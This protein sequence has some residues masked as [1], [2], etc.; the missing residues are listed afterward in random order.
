M[1]GREWQ[2]VI[3]A[4]RTNL[5]PGI[6]A[7]LIQLAGSHDKETCFVLT[8]GGVFR[9]RANPADPRTF[10]LCSGAAPTRTGT[11][12]TP[13]WDH[14]ARVLWAGG[15]IAKRYRRP[16]PNQ[17]AILTAF[18]E[19][20][21]PCRIDDPLPPKGEVCPKAR[22]H[23]TIKWLNRGQ[24]RFLLRFLGDGTGEGVCWEPVTISAL[25]SR[26]DAAKRMRL[27]A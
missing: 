7:A 11:L 10:R 3:E 4:G 8:C 9:A 2:Q 21:W 18:E 22:L 5:A 1:A 16:S 13:R 26:G 15:Q 14:E 27:A 24:K 23:D 6:R 20:G 17:E 25:L 19:D 12:F